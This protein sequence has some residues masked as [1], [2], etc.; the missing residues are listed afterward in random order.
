MI[1]LRHTHGIECVLN[2]N[3]PPAILLRESYR[4]D[5]KFK[6]RTL[7]NFSKCP[8]HAIEAL[9]ASLKDG[10]SSPAGTNSSASNSQA[11][12][13]LSQQSEITASTPTATSPPS[14]AP[15]SAS[16]CQEC[17]TALTLTRATALVA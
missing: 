1:P 10:P 5:G 2:R 12:T 11:A 16:A 3:S 17:S 4:E 6:K 8:P 9:K 14:S 13:P 15:S 7:A